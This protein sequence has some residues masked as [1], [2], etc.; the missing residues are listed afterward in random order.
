MLEKINIKK[1]NPPIG[2]G[3]KLKGLKKFNIIVGKN[4]SG[5]TRFFNS[6]YEQYKNDNNVQVVYIQA[7]QINPEDIRFRSGVVD[8]SFIDMLLTLFGD[9]IQLGNPKV[10]RG[11]IKGFIKEVEEKF[12]AVCGKSDCGLKIPLEQNFDKGEIIR[13]MV[14]PITT[15][16][17]SEDGTLI[18]LGDVGQG[19]QRLFIASLFQTYADKQKDTDQN[20]LILF[21]EP[22]LFLHPELKRSVNASLKRIAS[23]PNHQVIIST[24]DPYFL[25][26]NMNDED[27][28]LYSFEIDDDGET[29]VVTE[30]VGFGVEDEMLHISLFSKMVKEMERAGMQCTLGDN[31]RIT[32]DSLVALDEGYGFEKKTYTFNGQGHEVILPIYVRNKI[33][34]SENTDNLD[35]TQEELVQ[36]IRDLNHL[37]GLLYKNPKSPPS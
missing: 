7:N 23:L 11:E 4:N 30:S 20:I 29:E 14:K 34:H 36:S 28:A 33:H 25:W 32:S 35:Y 24:H 18:K 5:K 16:L 6:V 3:F 22:E 26:S 13:S 27:T 21:D 10:V 1:G 37:L 31:M 9:A 15:D 8:I 17:Q 2:T 19:Y 12:R